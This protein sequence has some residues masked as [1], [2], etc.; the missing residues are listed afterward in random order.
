MWINNSKPVLKVIKLVF[1]CCLILFVW[2]PLDQTSSDYTVWFH[3]DIR[4]EVIATL[5]TENVILYDSL[6]LLPVI[7]GTCWSKNTGQKLM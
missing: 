5:K 6:L 7:S 4:L 3:S 2:E 1:L